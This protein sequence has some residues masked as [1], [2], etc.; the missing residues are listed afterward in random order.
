MKKSKKFEGK[1]YNYAPIPRQRNI[2]S[3][4]EYIEQRLDD[5]INWHKRKSDWN[6]SKYSALKNFDTIIA[7][8]VPLSL[9]LGAVYDSA[10][11]IATK[12][13]TVWITKIASALSGVY[14]AISAGFFELEGYESNAKNY[15]KLYK[16]LES[17]KFKYLSRAEPYD[18]EDA[19]PRL[20]FTVENE[21]HQDVINFFN[22]NKNSGEAQKTAEEQTVDDKVKHEQ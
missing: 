17:E 6:K 13:I 5:Q 14:L 16:K 1:A 8:L 11:P 4:Q 15:K 12:H 2:L 9:G 21:L 19:F 22:S 18:E 10:D 20:I 3:D 7:A